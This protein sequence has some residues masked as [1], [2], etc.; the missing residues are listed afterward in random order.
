MPRDLVR[1]MAAWLA[2]VSSSG[3]WNSLDDPF[4]PCDSQSFPANSLWRPMHSASPLSGCSAGMREEREEK[5]RSINSSQDRSLRDRAWHAERWWLAK[6]IRSIF[7][8]SICLYR[9]GY[10]SSS[11]IPP[12][13][14][15]S[16]SSRS[17]GSI[18]Q[19]HWDCSNTFKTL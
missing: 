19:V 7:Q 8:Q 12:T 10:R 9:S 15:F 16:P 11:S 1:V 18:Q 17:S 14:F 6:I 2:S 3:P 13:P 5:A 4:Q